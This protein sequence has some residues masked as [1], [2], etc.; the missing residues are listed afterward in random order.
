MKHVLAA[1]GIDALKAEVQ[2]LLVMK[3]VNQERIE[4]LVS[5]LPAYTHSCTD[6]AGQWLFRAPSPWT[7]LAEVKSFKKARSDPVGLP[8]LEFFRNYSTSFPAWAELAEDIFILSPSSAAVERVFSVLRDKF[9][10]KT[11]QALVDYITASLMLR[12]NE[13]EIVP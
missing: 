5:E 3:C 7:T 2:T 4:A 1:R 6:Y 12:A 13:R 9:D 8:I 11:L 10:S